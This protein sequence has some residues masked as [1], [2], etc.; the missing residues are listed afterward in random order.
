M[1]F[2]LL[3]PHRYF[4][5]RN[6]IKFQIVFLPGS[7]CTTFLKSNA[8]II[9]KIPGAIRHWQVELELKQ[10]AESCL[11]LVTP[12]DTIQ[13]TMNNI[14][15]Y[16]FMIQIKSDEFQFNILER[17]GLMIS[18]QVSIHILFYKKILGSLYIHSYISY[19]LK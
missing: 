6:V 15:R 3:D 11:E 8:I 1:A 2:K 12:M 10:P 16:D 4:H 19:A 14:T 13:L 18:E 17:N 9:P 7:K 5:T